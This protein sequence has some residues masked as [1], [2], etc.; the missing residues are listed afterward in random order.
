MRAEESEDDSVTNDVPVISEPWTMNMPLLQL[1]K[2]V[3]L[4]PLHYLLIVF[5]LP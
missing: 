2:A 5:I 1:N 3:S 4:L